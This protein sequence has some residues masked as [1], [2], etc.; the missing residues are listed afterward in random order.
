MEW[1]DRIFEMKEI[2]SKGSEELE[3]VIRFFSTL[4]K[5][6][7]EHYELENIGPS[8]KRKADPDLPSGMMTKKAHKDASYM[9]G[10]ERDKQGYDANNTRGLRMLLARPLAGSSMAIFHHIIS[11]LSLCLLKKISPD[12]LDDFVFES[13]N[14]MDQFSSLIQSTPSRWQC[15][16]RKETLW[17]QAGRPGPPSS[18]ASVAWIDMG[19]SRCHILM[20]RWCCKTPPVNE[21]LA[22]ICR[23]YMNTA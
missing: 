18:R 9:M 1:A 2:V 12:N 20:I 7:V 5:G 11:T 6:S 17:S 8:I 4:Q 10:K 21:Y 23:R 16:P 15:I 22:Q 3:V 13:A 14:F 19:T